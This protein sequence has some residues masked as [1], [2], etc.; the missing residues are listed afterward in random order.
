MRGM[1]RKRFCQQ[2]PPMKA[3]SVMASDRAASLN[4]IAL[5]STTNN[6]P[7][8]AGVF[9]DLDAPGAQALLGGRLCANM[10]GFSQTYGGGR[11]G[12]L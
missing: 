11:E 4:I 1:R 6:Y 12:R 3:G 8:M 10:A 5:T 2:E 7:P 9:A